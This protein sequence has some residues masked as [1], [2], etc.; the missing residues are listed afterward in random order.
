MRLRHTISAAVLSLAVWLW[1][2]GHALA[3]DDDGLAPY[4]ADLLLRMADTTH[5]ILSLWVSANHT[6][7]DPRGEG[8]VSWLVDRVL[9][10]AA[11]FA[12]CLDQLTLLTFG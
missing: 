8:V 6:L 7:T 11:Y 4:V 2:S 1:A 10:F 5:D 3:Q 9:F 12:E